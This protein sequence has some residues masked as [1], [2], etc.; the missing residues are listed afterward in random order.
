MSVRLSA[1]VF[2]AFLKTKAVKQLQSQAEFIL[3][4]FPYTSSNLTLAKKLHL[5]T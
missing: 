5:W 4:V 3:L 1:R 2:D